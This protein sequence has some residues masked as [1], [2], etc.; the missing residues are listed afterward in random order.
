MRCVRCKAYMNPLIIFIDGGKRFQC[1]LCNAKSE[2]PDAYFDHL[3][4]TGKRNDAY[5]RPELSAGSYDLEATE[6]YCEDKQ[7][8]NAPAFIFVI[9]VSRAAVKSGFVRL[10]CSEFV[11]RILPCLPK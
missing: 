2:V 11:E 3:D 9:D 1:N 6:D 8:P 10:F 7:L 4:H 5:I